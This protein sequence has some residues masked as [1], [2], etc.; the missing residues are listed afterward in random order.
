[1]SDIVSDSVGPSEAGAWLSLE[2]AARFLRVTVRTIDR[3]GLPKRRLPGRPTE[4]WVA[5]AD[6]SVSDV[7][8][9]SD[10]HIG[11]ADER[12]IALSERVSDVVGRQMAPLLAE[13]AASRQRIED[14]ARENGR[15]TAELAAERAKSATDASTAPQSSELAPGS[16][17]GPSSVRWPVWAP[18]ALAMLA[19]VAVVLVV[20]LR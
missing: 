11:H 10:G 3:R 6:D 2:D 18:W 7:T 17:S 1:M 20:W 12:A 8:E 16:S 19:T 9:T 15:L 4:V 13:L 5:G 14:L